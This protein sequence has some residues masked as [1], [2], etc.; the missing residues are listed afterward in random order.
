MT[1]N[2]VKSQSFFPNE[3]E[4]TGVLSPLAAKYPSS[5]DPTQGSQKSYPT[6]SSDHPLG[7]QLAR[8]L[9]VSCKCSPPETW[10]MARGKGLSKPHT[11]YHFILCK[12]TLQMLMKY[13]VGRLTLP[14]EDLGPLVT[15]GEK[16]H[17]KL[18]EKCQWRTKTI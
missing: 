7:C 14:L 3:M 13:F 2:G 6:P 11:P 10:C 9:H 18:G 8:Q 5:S 15:L 4:G 12:V 17:V 1:I 16:N